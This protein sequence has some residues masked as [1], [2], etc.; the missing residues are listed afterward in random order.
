MQHLAAVPVEDFLSQLGLESLGPVLAENEVDVEAL[1][2]MAPDDFDELGID[3]SAQVRVH[4]KLA[5]LRDTAAGLE[6]HATP[7]G[8]EAAA[9]LHWWMSDCLLLRQDLF[10]LVARGSIED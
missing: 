6:E 2:L 5:E 8:T 7:Q 10:V 9:L 1:A 3:P 4:G